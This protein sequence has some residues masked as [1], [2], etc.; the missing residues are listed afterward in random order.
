MIRMSFNLPLSIQSHA[1]FQLPFFVVSHQSL[2]FPVV[3]RITTQNA[4]DQIKAC[5]KR[6]VFSR[7]NLHDRGPGNQPGLTSPQ[8]RTAQDHVIQPGLHTRGHPASPS[9]FPIRLDGEVQRR[10]IDGNVV[11]DGARDVVGWFRIDG[12]Q[13]D[14]LTGCERG[15]RVGG[16]GN[17]RVGRD[18]DGRVGGRAVGDEGAEQRAGFA[19]GQG[20]VVCG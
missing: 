4:S 13:C 9:T 8:H 2:A 7:S 16:E 1:T 11:E 15:E 10:S 5:R 12:G 19:E 3:D 14:G 20:C 6:G 17:G 18:V